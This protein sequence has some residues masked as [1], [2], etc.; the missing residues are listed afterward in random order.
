MWTLNNDWGVS[1][2]TLSCYIRLMVLGIILS[3]FSNVADA[4]KSTLS[5]TLTAAG[6]LNTFILPLDC[7]RFSAY[8]TQTLVFGDSNTRSFTI[9]S[10]RQGCQYGGPRITCCPPNYELGQYNSPG[11]CPGGY[12]THSDIEFVAVTKSTDGFW[13]TYPAIGTMTGKLCCPSVTESIK[14]T[15]DG[16]VPICLATTKGPTVT[17]DGTRTLNTVG[18]SPSIAQETSSDGRQQI[19]GNT[20]SN[21]PTTLPSQGSGSGTGGKSLSG[22]AIAGIAIGVAVPVIVAGLYF[23]YR[24]GRRSHKRLDKFKSRDPAVAVKDFPGGGQEPGVPVPSVIG[25]IQS[26]G[27]GVST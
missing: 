14:Y 4:Q 18:T 6:P 9:T 3:D 10:F 5:V 13:I 27:K 24:F 1:P 12:T 21:V 7:S 17:G 11:V 16:P 15:A 2:W 23:A 19:P 26:G 20:A 25:G 22:G 8:S